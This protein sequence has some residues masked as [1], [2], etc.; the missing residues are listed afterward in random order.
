M[1]YL[2][3][4]VGTT[5]CK[6]QLFSKEGEI[7]EYLSQ[8]Y[9]FKRCGKDNYINVDVLWTNIRAMIQEVSQRHEISSMCISSL[10]ESFV[11]LDKD[12]S[13]L[14]YPMLYTDPRGEEEAKEAGIQLGE[15]A[16]YDIT[17]VIPHSMYSLYKLL[18]IKKND[19]E[20]FAKANKVLLICDYIGYLL[21]GERNIDYGLAA[22]TGA[23][24]VTKMEFSDKVLSLL[25]IDKALFSTPKPTGAVVGKIKE[26]LCSELGIKGE[27]VLVLGSHDQVCTSLGAGAIS[28]GDAVDGMGTV[29]CI[30]T[31]FDKK[32][33]DVKMGRQ[34][35]PCVP[36]AVPGLYCTYILNYSCC[37]TINWMRKEIMHDYCADEKNYF[38]YIEKDIKSS[39]SG[40]LALPYFGGA[41]TPYQDLGAKG[42]IIGLTTQTSDAEVF[43]A[44]MEGTAM[45]MR[46]NAEVVSEYGINIKNAVATGGGANSDIW[47]TLKADI[48]N[49]PIKVLRSSE[50]GLC[51]CAILQAVAL[52]GADSFEAA[53]EIFVRYT[54]QYVPNADVHASYGE[55]YGKYKKLYK[56][57]KELF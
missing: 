2:S 5:R 29:E 14:F 18:W 23:F 3:I 50:G 49:I 9:D 55:M 16:I 43:K 7:L 1:N 28:A 30:T 8:D 32:P 53:K 12:D 31:I 27:P 10:G 36:F 56:T 41:S 44:L 48:Q 33:H 25:G 17:G 37:S 24:D 54:K 26:S 15:E 6:C 11:L 4:D 47:L 42:A 39:P 51:G 34:G 40:I 21:T 35:Y 20:A 46:L 38:A 45:E 57:V 52:G 13:I 19:P 22:R